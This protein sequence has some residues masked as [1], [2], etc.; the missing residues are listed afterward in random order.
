VI[1]LRP[2]DADAYYLRATAHRRLKQDSEALADFL[3]VRKLGGTVP[4]ELLRSLAPSTQPA[5]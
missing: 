2:G 3:M 4:E 5:R 1:E